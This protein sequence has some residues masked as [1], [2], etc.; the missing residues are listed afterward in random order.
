MIEMTREEIN[1]FNEILRKRSELVQS[2]KEAAREHLIRMGV[3]TPEGRLS[4]WYKELVSRC[5]NKPIEDVCY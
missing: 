4:S 1:E 2:S 5:S 3:L